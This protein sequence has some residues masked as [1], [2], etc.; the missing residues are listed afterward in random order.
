[1]GVPSIGSD[2]Y[3]LR[4][5]IVDNQTG[6][7]VPPYESQALAAAMRQMVEKPDI[8]KTMGDTARRR[9]K[10]KFS[11]ARVVGAIL[12]DYESRLA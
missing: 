8:R 7:L 11:R 2:I 4:D 10:Q 12:Q 5:A 3:G 6:L 9:V 1:M